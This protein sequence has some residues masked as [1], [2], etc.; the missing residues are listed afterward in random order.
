MINL[1]VR[2]VLAAAGLV[3]LFLLIGSLLPRSFETSSSVSINAPA[4]Q[5][6]PCLN[7]L[8]QW[9]A[10]SPWNA[11]AIPGLSVEIGNPSSGVGATQTWV[12]PRGE[13]KLWIT[14]V[15]ETEQ[16]KFKSR[17]ANFPEMESSIVLKPEA[18]NATQVSWASRGSLPG[19]PFYGWFGLSFSSAL[20]E[21]YN[22][23]LSR[24]KETVEGKGD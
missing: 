6:F 9:Q 11:H 15:V 2:V 10:W 7:D 8:R 18:G 17:F 19:G 24:L 22:K 4:S 3:G 20:Q 16:V 14:D 5:I 1:L 12:E 13:G 23:S 21:E